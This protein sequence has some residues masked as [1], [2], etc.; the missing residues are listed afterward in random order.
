MQYTYYTT[1][2]RS[3]IGRVLRQQGG[4]A[5]HHLSGKSQPG[6]RPSQHCF[7][8]RSAACPLRVLLCTS[9]LTRNQH[10]AGL[11]HPRAGAQGANLVSRSGLSQRSD[12]EPDQEIA[13]V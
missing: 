13:T 11:F 2:R 8:A 4:A 5:G 9:L 10:H 3:Q 7:C 6:T 12:T 1:L